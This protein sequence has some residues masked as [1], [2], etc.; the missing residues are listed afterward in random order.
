MELDRELVAQA[1]RYI[2][3]A[4]VHYIKTWIFCYEESLPNSASRER[5]E[6]LLRDFVRSKALLAASRSV[7][8]IQR[9]RLDAA[10]A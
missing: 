2:D 4:N 7:I 6:A 3:G 8:E 9:R 1:R 10:R 5:Y